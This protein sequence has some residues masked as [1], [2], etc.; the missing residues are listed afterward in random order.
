MGL[1]GLIGQAVRTAGGVAELSLRELGRAEKLG[2][3]VLRSR[4]D[5]AQPPAGLPPPHEVRDNFAGRCDGQAGELRDQMDRLLQRAVGQSSTGGRLQLYS[6]LL[7]QLVP[8]EARILAALSDSR[9]AAVVHVFPRSA[10]GGHTTGLLENASSIGRTAG[11]ALPHLI[12]T[13]MTHLLQ[14]GLVELG[15]EDPGLESEYELLMAETV[16]REALA[17]GRRPGRLP[18]RV[19]RA[20]VRLS[21]LGL[22]LWA[23]SRGHVVG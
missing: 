19:V 11:V 9:S 18:P 22:E 10:R 21:Q 14:L 20:T 7:G 16:V 13:Y 17:Q 1:G 4:L 6:S 23:T 3:R 15:P 5:A 2:M 8:D 12:A